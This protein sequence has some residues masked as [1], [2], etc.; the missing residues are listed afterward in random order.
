M[1]DKNVTSRDDAG[2]IEKYIDQGDGT[3]AR[4]VVA[5]A[6]AATAGAAGYPAG[7]VPV[8]ARSGNVANATAAAILPAAVGKTTYV[9]HVSV[10]GAG[11]TAAGVVGAALLGVLGGDWTM[12]VA[13]PAGPT[14]GITPIVLQ[15]NPPLPA[16]AVN[17]GIT[18]S[19][20]ALGAGNTN[21]AVTI[22]GF[23]L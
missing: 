8:A 3:W 23:Q 7:A 5:Q 10:T 20:S 6:A 9:T 18:I 21:A 13:V 12:I 19:L 17:S 1:A 14:T 2:V 22:A 4:R 15:F 11:A 16:A